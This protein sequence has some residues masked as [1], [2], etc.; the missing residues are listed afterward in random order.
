MRRLR[1]G[2]GSR[3]DLGGS[4]RSPGSGF[5]VQGF[6]GSAG[7][8]DDDGLLFWMIGNPLGLPL[9]AFL[10]PRPSYVAQTIR[11]MHSGTIGLP[12]SHT[13]TLPHTP[14]LRST[15]RRR[16]R[17]CVTRHVAGSGMLR[18]PAYCG[19]RRTCLVAS[20][21]TLLLTRCARKSASLHEPSL[22]AAVDSNVWFS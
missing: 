17:C 5:G 22:G 21:P 18:D 20:R 9:P 4:L 14:P 10:D 1:S 6:L 13:H 15:A 3:E 19:T 2:V 12:H 16:A 11:R 7:A 8:V